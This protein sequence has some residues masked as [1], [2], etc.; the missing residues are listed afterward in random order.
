[1]CPLH[2]G[3]L[4]GTGPRNGGCWMN[5]PTRVRFRLSLNRRTAGGCDALDL[6]LFARM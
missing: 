2:S 6:S 4:P 3:I 1:M 5:V